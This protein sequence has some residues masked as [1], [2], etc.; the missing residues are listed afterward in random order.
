MLLIFVT[1]D[2]QVRDVA[3]AEFGADLVQPHG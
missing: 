1:L 3:S 2:L